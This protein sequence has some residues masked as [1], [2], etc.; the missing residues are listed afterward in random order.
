MVNNINNIQ[1]IRDAINRVITEEGGYSNHPADLGGKTKYGITQRTWSDYRVSDYDHLANDWPKDVKDVTL[2]L[3]ENYYQYRFN[4]A[5]IELLP[6]ELY[7]IVFDFEVNAGRNAIKVLQRLVEVNDDGFIGE[8]T[9]SATE[10]Q[11]DGRPINELLY[12]Y[13]RKRID[14]YF[15]LAKN[16]PSQ[17]VFVRGWCQRALNTLSAAVFVAEN[18]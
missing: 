4:E 14:Y 13:T 2:E 10:L 15:Q 7:S 3:A 6:P 1:L 11:I 5:N 17:Q 12:E 16:L 9:A 18:L 8:I